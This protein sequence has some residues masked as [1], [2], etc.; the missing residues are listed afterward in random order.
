MGRPGVHGNKILWHLHARIYNLTILS[1]HIIG[2]S[3][4]D[5]DSIIAVVVAVVIIVMYYDNI[6][7]LSE[8]GSLTQVLH[9]HKVYHIYII[10]TYN[11]I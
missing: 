4:W 10:C 9:A 7:V 2:P 3:A 5:E 8:N 11:I 1:L 6:Q